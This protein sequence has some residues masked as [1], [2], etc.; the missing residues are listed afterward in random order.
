MDPARTRKVTTLQSNYM[1][2]HKHKEI[3]QAKKRR[4]LLMRLLTLG[5]FVAIGA[6]L[7]V[8]TFMSQHQTLKEQ[9]E[10]KAQLEQELKELKQESVYLEEEIVKLQDEEYIAKIARRDYF[11]SENGEVIFNLPTNESSY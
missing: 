11:L 9:E 3:V 1:N 2:Q 6:V 4:M 7:V 8:S 5:V 10:T